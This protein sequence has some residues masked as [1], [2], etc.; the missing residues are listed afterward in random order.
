[1]AAL[2]FIGA[3]LFFIVP[4]MLE[5]LDPVVYFS[6]LLILGMCCAAIFNFFREIIKNAKI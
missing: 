4:P 2:I 3:I 1:M 5:S 6:G